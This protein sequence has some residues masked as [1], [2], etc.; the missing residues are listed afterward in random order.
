ME[1]CIF[2]KILNGEIP[3]KRIYEDDLVLVN[4]FREDEFYSKVCSDENNRNHR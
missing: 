4:D 3:S 1:N 2:C